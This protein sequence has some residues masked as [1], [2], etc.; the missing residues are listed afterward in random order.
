VNAVTVRQRPE[1]LGS[2]AR[3]FWALTWTLAATEFKLR[4][5]G[6]ALGIAWSL[7]RPFALFAVL[8]IVFDEIAG[9]G[10][11]IHN[12]PAYILTTMVLFN[13]FAEVAGGCVNCL[14]TRENL[15]RKIRFPRLVI[16]MSV[17][18]TAL[19]NLGMTLVAVLGFLVVVSGLQPAVGWLQLVP[20]VVLVLCFAL[21]LGLLMAALFVRFRDIQPIWD[22]ASQMLFYASPILY[23]STTVPAKYQHAYMTNPIASLLAEMRAAV[24]DPTAPHAATLIGGTVRLLIPLG[25]I[26]GAVV[27]GAWVFNREAPRIAENL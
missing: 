15:L 5:Y 25:I 20:V 7:V 21:G 6:S 4:F 2:D 19:L 18:L 13:F 12:Y 27:V 22:V 16:P 9:L 11:G 8:W 23:V 3:R 24:I 1:L 17:A 26:V 10:D 14:T